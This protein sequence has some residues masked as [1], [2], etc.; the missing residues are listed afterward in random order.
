MSVSDNFQTL[1]YV[2]KRINKYTNCV[3]FI[4][5]L[6]N[7]MNWQYLMSLCIIYKV[8]PCQLGMVVLILLSNMGINTIWLV[9]KLYKIVSSPNSSFH[10]VQRAIS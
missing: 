6:M 8:G 10:V 1:N 5:I 9:C 4:L 3:Y 7:F 2:V